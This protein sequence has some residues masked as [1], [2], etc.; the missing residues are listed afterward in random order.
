M[1]RA[2]FGDRGHEQRGAGPELLLVVPDA[3]VV[4]GPDG[5]RVGVRTGGTPTG[6]HGGGD[7]TAY[8]CGRVL[9]RPFQGGIADR[10]VQSGPQCL[11]AYDGVG[12]CEPV[13]QEADVPVDGRGDNGEPP[14]VRPPRAQLVEQRPQPAVPFP[15]LV[16]RPRG[17]RTHPSGVGERVEDAVKG[18]DGC[19]GVMGFAGH[20]GHCGAAAALVRQVFPE[21]VEPERLASRAD[22]RQG[23]CVRVRAR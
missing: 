15:P 23:C 20:A 6:D 21:A 14:A 12:G 11:S 16:P 7:L 8:G 9:H 1:C 17:Q 19:T 13:L 5:D 22:R 3:G 18:I 4:G 2:G 10:P